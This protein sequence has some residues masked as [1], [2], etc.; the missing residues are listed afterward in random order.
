M[1]ATVLAHRRPLLAY[2]RA[3]IARRNAHAFAAGEQS[4]RRDTARLLRDI[5]AEIDAG[6]H[7]PLI[8]AAAARLIALRGTK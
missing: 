5:A 8:L 1:P 3:A 7:G 4:R 6:E 2:D